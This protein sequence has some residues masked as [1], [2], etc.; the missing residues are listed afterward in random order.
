MNEREMYLDTIFFKNPDRLP[1][2]PGLGRIS[3]LKRWHSEGLPADIVSAEGAIEYAYRMAGGIEQ[4]PK[5]GD[6]F[7]VNSMMMPGYEEKVIEQKANS[8]IVQDWQGNICEIANEYPL[9]Y[10]RWGHGFRYKA[11]D[12]IPGGDPCRLGRHEKT[13]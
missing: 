5:E 11:L 13:V 7:W 4:L 3:T 8:K 12:K 6:G 2:A 9:E 10:L 1:F